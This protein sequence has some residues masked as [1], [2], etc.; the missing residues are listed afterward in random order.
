MTTAISQHVAALSGT[1]PAIP[2]QPTAL[3]KSR[4]AELSVAQLM[5]T[6]L[7]QLVAE[8]HVT[9]D[10]SSITDPTFTGYMY[11]TRDNVVVSL[12]PNRSELEHDCMARY[13]IGRAFDVEGLPPLPEPFAVTDLTG[14]SDPDM[15][16]ALR[17]VRQGGGR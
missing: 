6:P 9:L 1:L 10:E 12:P 17:R 7:E 15:D 13:F 3:D 11:A 4:A 16:E 14:D 5:D 8:L 2:K